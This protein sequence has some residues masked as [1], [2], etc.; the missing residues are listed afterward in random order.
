[1]SL[2]SEIH[3][4][5][6]KTFLEA[7]GVDA[8]NFSVEIPPEGFGDY[9][10]NIAMTNAKT[11]KMSPRQIAEK[12]SKF[13][14]KESWFD[15]ISI[16]GPGF[17]NFNLSKSVYL[18]TLSDTLREVK[19]PKVEN[20]RKIQFEFVSANPTGPLTV[21]HGRQAIIGDVLSKVYQS[22]GYDVIR[23]YYFND[24]GRQMRMLGHS[25]WVRYEKLYG[26][27]VEFGEDDYRGEYLADV[28][29]KFADE[30]EDAYIDKWNEETQKFFTAYAREKM[31]EWIK[32]SLSDIDVNFDVYFNESSL[33][34]NGTT[35]DAMKILKEG[36][37]VYEKDGTT[38]FAV[39]K[40][41]PNE[42]DR[43][44]VRKSG[45]PTYFFS[46]VAYMLDK[47]RR[48]FDRV[49]YIWGADHHGYI[50]R[51][52]AAARALNLPNGFF[53]VIIHQFVTLKSGDEVVRMSKRQGEFT[54]LEDL[55]KRVGKDATRYFFAML[56]PN[57]HL[58]FD[59]D[60]A[61][62]KKMDNPVY[63][64]QYAHA[65]I[66]SLLENAIMKGVKWNNSSLEHLG[67][68]MEFSLI[69]E[70]AEFPEVILSIVNENKPQKL[71]NYAYSLAE[72]FHSY[73]NSNKVVDVENPQLSAD[74]INLC[75]GVRNVL[76]SVLSLLGVSAP[77]SM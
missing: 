5:L 45:E 24:A 57:T 33:Y 37:F 13:L 17:M 72:K 12:L 70:I 28:A 43:V 61:E 18:K 3:D 19:I 25:L 9:S 32:K 36:D 58:V 69:R 59:V 53:N 42:E 62:S 56:D 6:S 31:F 41:L 49:F 20:K 67:N 51:M 30:Y 50:P 74:R 1:M 15:E 68:P 52:Q 48:G 38:W 71:C 54:T 23:E 29:K 76:E 64:I 11:L 60:L 75:L 22:V 10:S 27:D 63:Y 4:R 7:F 73:Y 16:A 55:V 66:S 77:K 8:R 40:I 47:Y 21:G 14:K 34:K 44:I 65:R 35:D 2:R 26:R 39:S 46:D